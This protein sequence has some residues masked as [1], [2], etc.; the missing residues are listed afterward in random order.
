MGRLFITEFSLNKQFFFCG[1][2][3]NHI[4]LRE[5]YLYKNEHDQPN[6]NIGYFE[7]AVNL[8]IDNHGMQDVNTWVSCVKCRIPFGVKWIQTDRPTA[9]IKG[10]RFQLYL[11]GFRYWDGHRAHHANLLSP[12]SPPSPPPEI[13]EIPNEDDDNVVQEHPNEA[14]V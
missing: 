13:M 12:P 3:K 8:L 14:L 9:A 1:H 4:A 10:G 7:N 11:C 2:C 6:K 5:D